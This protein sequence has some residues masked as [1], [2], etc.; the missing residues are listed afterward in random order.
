MTPQQTEEH[1]Q[2]RVES[3][4]AGADSVVMTFRQWC[5][6]NGFSVPTG[7]R[8]RKSGTGPRFI[9]LSARRIGVSVGENRRWQESRAT[10]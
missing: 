9:K 1:H 4:R 10:A 8:I 7:Y 6:C 5:A 3:L 2:R